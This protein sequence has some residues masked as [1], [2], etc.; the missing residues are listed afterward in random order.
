MTFWKRVTEPE[1]T[2]WSLREL[3]VACATRG[4]RQEGPKELLIQ[5]LMREVWRDKKAEERERIM[6]ALQVRAPRDNCARVRH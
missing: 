6:K 3:R 1:L 4:L 2:T 5:R